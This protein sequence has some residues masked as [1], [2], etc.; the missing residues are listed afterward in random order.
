MI[1]FKETFFELVGTRHSGST[2]GA[3][4]RELVTGAPVKP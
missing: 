1:C 2:L 3:F 4:G